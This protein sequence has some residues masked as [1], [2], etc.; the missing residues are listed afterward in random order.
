MSLPFIEKLFNSV[1]QRVKKDIY[2]TGDLNDIN[3]T[4]V[5][6]FA[7]GC[8]NVPWTDTNGGHLVTIKM[9]DNYIY[10]FAVNALTGAKYERIKA[11]GTW[12]PW[13]GITKITEGNVTGDFNGYTETGI[14][15]YGGQ[16]YANKPAN[17]GILEVLKRGSFIV[18]RCTGS[19]S[20][21]IRFYNGSTWSA[22]TTK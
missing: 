16:N 8:L 17:F 2:Y 21:C 19:N 1:E 7:Y 10:Q 11:S 14:Y 4:E 15:Q 18:Q 20:I 5:G 9:S 22:W 13:E 6:N 12:K 3:N